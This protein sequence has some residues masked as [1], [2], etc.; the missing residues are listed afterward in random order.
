[1]SIFTPTNQIRLTNVAVVRMKKGGK[2]FEIACYKN[3]VVNWRAGA[4]KDLD[5]VL[6]TQSVFV[7]VSKGQ[8]A[9]KEDLTKSFGTD[10]L[11]EICKQILAKGELQVSDKE[12]H[13]QLETMFR[14]IA[15]IVAEKC[16]NPE[17]KRPYTVSLIEG[18]MKEIHYSVK[19]NK[20]TKQQALE[21]I[22]QLKESMGIQRAHMRLRLVLPAKEAKRL[23]EKL[24]P[25]LQVVE[26]EDFDEQL[27]MVCL[28][29]PG[30]FR[31]I[32][33]LIRSE[34]RGRGSLE[35]VSL[36]DVEEGEE[37]F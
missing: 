1:M 33:E 24:K 16:V 37:K 31:E 27:E 22:R 20:S 7:N 36:K 28:V 23:K 6:Q 12:R 19:A 34:T 13:S 25:L 11:T 35:V 3:K 14:D 9:K 29:D 15:T 32:D 4:E 5:E 18:A 26:S 17:T 8:V 2:R 30:C 21:V 10:D